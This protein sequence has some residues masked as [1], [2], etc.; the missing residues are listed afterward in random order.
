MTTAADGRVV[1]LYT[2][3]SKGEP[4]VASESLSVLDG[5]IEGDRYRRGT[6]Y[7]SATDGCQVTLV[8][9]AALD[10]A[11]DEFGIDLATGQHRRNV[12]VRGVGLADLLD[13]TFELGEAE[14]RGTRL[15]PPC[16]YLGKLV[17]DPAVVEALRERRGGICADVVTP[18]R[19]SV[20]DEVRIIEANPRELG[21]QIADRLAG[22]T[23]EEGEQD[24]GTDETTGGHE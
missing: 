14:L 3:P 9:G 5:G 16:G 19:V 22:R 11:T 18:G 6:G 7:Y 17:G 2:T 10:A 1:E 13:A 15:R 23:V 21:R 4:M 20:G 24:E 8:D 12:V